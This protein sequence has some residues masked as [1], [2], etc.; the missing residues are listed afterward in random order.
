MGKLSG[1]QVFCPLNEVWPIKTSDIV[2]NDYVRIH[3][4]D[5]VPPSMKELCFIIKREDLGPDDV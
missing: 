5:E 1:F 3:L 2:S 4:F